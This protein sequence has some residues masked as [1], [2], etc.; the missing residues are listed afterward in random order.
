MTVKKFIALTTA[1]IAV[2]TAA[3]AQVAVDVVSAYVFRGVTLVDEVN[4]QPGFDTTAFGGLVSVGTWANFNTD[5][6]QFDEI[7]YFFGIPLTGEDSPVSVELGYTEYTYPGAEGDADREPYLSFGLG[8]ASLLVAYGIDGAVDKSLYAELGYGYGMDLTENLSGAIS[9]ALAYA[10]IDGGESGL[11]HFQITG[12]LD[13]SIP[14]TDYVISVSVTHIVQIDDD[15]LTDAV[16]DDPATPDVD[17]S[18]AGYDVETY[19]TVGT[20]F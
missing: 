7:D 19:V 12:G 18:A 11:S 17:E 4:V 15:V 20:T 5:T 9:A 14:E 16:S 8:D 10:D 13:L 1:A 2:T 6:S 3:S